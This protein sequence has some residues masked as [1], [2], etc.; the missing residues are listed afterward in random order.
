MLPRV[1]EPRQDAH[2]LRRRSALGPEVGNQVLRRQVPP[3]H[4]S[5]PQQQ[6]FCR[7]FV[8]LPLLGRPS[9]AAPLDENV[10]RAVG[11]DANVC[12]QLLL[13]FSRVSRTIRAGL[14]VLVPVAGTQGKSRQVIAGLPDRVITMGPSPHGPG[15]LVLDDQATVDRVCPAEERRG[16]DRFLVFGRRE[17]GKCPRKTISTFTRRSSSEKEIFAASA[18]FF[19]TD[20]TSTSWAEV[21]SPFRLGLLLRFTAAPHCPRRAGHVGGQDKRWSPPTATTPASVVKILSAVPSRRRP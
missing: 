2:H 12:R 4:C 5:E 13:L 16:L 1:H 18:S 9:P 21:A 10:H 3:V 6:L 11:R 7:V 8:E 19:V 17:V 15:L 14:G 20:A